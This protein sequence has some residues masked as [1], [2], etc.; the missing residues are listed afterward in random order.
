[1]DIY[2]STKSAYVFIFPGQFADLNKLIEGSKDHWSKYKHQKAIGTNKANVIAKQYK[3]ANRQHKLHFP[4]KKPVLI[5]A[6]F[7]EKDK[8]RDPDGFVSWA[9]KCIL[10]GLQEA[11]IL[12]NDGF[13]NITNFVFNWDVDKKNPRVEVLLFPGD[14]LNFIEKSDGI[15]PKSNTGNKELHGQ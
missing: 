9:M 7:Y 10:D 14:S 12:S 11:E 2:F 6:N 15:N 13:N 3:G 4:L 1:M 8:R 5:V